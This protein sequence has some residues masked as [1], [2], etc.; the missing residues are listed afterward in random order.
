MHQSVTHVV[1]SYKTPNVRRQARAACGASPCKP[2][3]GG[4]PQHLA[5]T[6]KAD[7]VSMGNVSQWRAQGDQ[8][9]FKRA[10]IARPMTQFLSSSDR[11]LSSSV[12][13]VMRWR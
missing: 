3:F 10:R 5:A 8:T 7:V 9:Q 6:M 4:T 2:L 12:K 1:T 13:C 11:N